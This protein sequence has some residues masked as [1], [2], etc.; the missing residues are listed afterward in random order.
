MHK[1]SYLILSLLVSTLI[2]S[3]VGDRNSDN[4]VD[5]S[6]VDNEASSLDQPEDISLL[7]WNYDAKGDSMVKNDIPDDLTVNFVLDVLNKRYEKIDLNLVR[8]SA[9]TVFVKLDDASY[10]GQLGSTGNYAF[11]AEVVYCLTEVPN[12]NSVNFDF[13]ESDHAAPGLYNRKNFDNKIVE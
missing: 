10:L 5:D 8:T 13:P 1:L 7:L 2:F 9:D 3:C 12:I 4:N 11:M 6:S